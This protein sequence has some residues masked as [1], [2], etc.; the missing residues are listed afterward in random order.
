MRQSYFWWCPW[1]AAGLLGKWGLGLSLSFLCTESLKRAGHFVLSR[2]S[3]LFLLVS[4][5]SSQDVTA[6]TMQGTGKV[7]KSSLFKGRQP[8]LARTPSTLSPLPSKLISFS[9]FSPFLF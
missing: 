1:P 6:Q 5:T 8:P 9:P 4:P 3:V 2:T 7:P